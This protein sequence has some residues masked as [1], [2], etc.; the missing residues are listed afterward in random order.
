MAVIKGQVQRH[1][2]VSFDAAIEDSDQLLL[3]SFEREDVAEGVNSYLAG[4][5]PAFPQWRRT[6]DVRTGSR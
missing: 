6:A 4:R 5:A 1:L 2:D 3:E